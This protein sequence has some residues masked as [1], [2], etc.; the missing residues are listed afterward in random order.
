MDSSVAL[1]KLR[2]ICSKQEKSPADIVK[3]LKKWGIESQHHLQIINKLKS[4]KF[5]D[6]NRYAAAFVKDKIKFDHWG[7]VKIRI[8]LKQKGIDSKTIDRII[9]EYDRN[10]YR[11]MIDHE[12]TKK[13]KTLKGTPYEIWAKLARYGSSRGYEMDIMADLLPSASA[14]GSE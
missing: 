8:M 14:D 12:L 5:I 6:E 9:G 11:I 7:F 13:R 2:N 3:L 10:E 1:D 4:E